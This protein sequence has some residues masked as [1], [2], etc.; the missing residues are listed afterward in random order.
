MRRSGSRSRREHGAL[1]GVEALEPRAL[2]AAARAAATPPVELLDT[3]EVAALLDRAAAVTS[4]SDAIIAVVDRSGRLLGLRVE[5]GVDPAITGNTHSLVF[6]VDGAL[7]KART[8]AFFGNNQAPLTARTI[9]LISQTTMTQREIQ[10]DPS[11]TDPDSTL[12]GPGFVA[13]IGIKNHF[14]P[15]IQFTP[16]VDLFAIEHTN[17]DSIVHPGA[18]RIKGTADDITLPY[19]FN[20]DP[21]FL[22]PAALADPLFA[23]E[24][25]GFISGLE[26]TAQSRGIATLPGGTP[27]VENGQ[28]VGGIGVFFPGKT[29]FATE[30]NSQLNDAGFFDP[31]RRDRSLEAEFIAFAAVGGSKGANASFAGPL[32]GAPALPGFDLPFGRIDL[33]GISLDLFGG[34][35]LQGLRNLLTFGR[36]LGPGTP[37]D[38]TNLPVD[39]Q[40]DTLLDGKGVPQGWIVMPHAGGDLTAADVTGIIRRGIREANRVRAAIRLPLDS[41]ARMV[42]SVTDKDG[43][44]LGLFR[45]PDATIF[46][47]DV[48][49]AKARNVSYYADPAELQAIDQIPGVAAGT[50]FTNRT[51]RYAALPRFPEGIDVYPPGPFSI[52]NDGGALRNGRNDGPPLPASAFQSAQGF[53]AFNPNTNFHDPFNVANQNGVV[54]FPGSAPL[55]KDTD[56]DGIRD[57]VGGLGISGDGVDQDD[58]VTFVSVKGFEPPGGLRADKVK[59]RGVRLP[60]IKFNRQP[61]VPGDQ[62]RLPFLKF[63]NLPAPRGPNRNK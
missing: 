9:Q 53:D 56:G 32:H 34:H 36:T 49:V 55:Y 11:I 24:S 13:P 7:A 29:G 52:F 21:A 28:V 47:I 50:A 4:S 57:L 25:Y 54:F 5:S 12:R 60:Y 20:I 51:F 22:S 40:G 48:A 10:S 35:G 6:A 2:M 41:T 38:G 63:K 62:A 37:N 46:S 33:V 1:P 59:V 39:P 19:R 16:Q 42:L 27:I 23:P 58:D 26:P 17:R 18:D 8:G 3:T 45:M 43:N 44:V 61:H 15:G 14:P 30:E 31:T